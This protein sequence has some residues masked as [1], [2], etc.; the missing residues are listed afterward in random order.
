MSVKWAYGVTTVPRRRDTLL[1]RTLRS[2]ANAGFDKPRL[3]VDGGDEATSV[4]YQEEFGC[5]V[6][7]RNPQVRAYGNWILGLWEL[8]L[9]EP[10]ADRYAMFQD[11]LEATRNL[12]AYLD[13]VELPE[14]G[15]W[16]LYTFPPVI[17]GIQAPPPA[18][19]RVGFFPSNQYGRGAVALVFPRKA[20]LEL[21]A[22]KET[23]ERPQDP[24]RGHRNIDGAVINTLK[25]RG[26][27]EYVHHPSL[28]QHTGIA[29]TIQGGRP[30]PQA[31]PW[32]GVEYDA[33]EFL[34]EKY[35]PWSKT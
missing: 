19:G 9:R 2:L 21:L 7:T 8:Y 29:T 27:T 28:V 30:H 23:V 12:R 33:T 1:P 26:F 11:D 32:L 3:F 13:K 6:S 10:D 4:S 22:S 34:G 5:S 20:I 25:P 14:C 17:P 24:Q 15:Y 18:D 35:V 16:N 31:N